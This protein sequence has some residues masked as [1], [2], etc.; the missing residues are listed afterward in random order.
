M[1]LSRRLRQKQRERKARLGRLPK[2]IHLGRGYL[3]KIEIITPTQIAEIL[4]IEEKDAVA[5]FWDDDDWVIY[6]DGSVSRKR[7]WEAYFHELIHA[8]HDTAELNRGG[9]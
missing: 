4:E 9:I 6:I 8:V 3:V 5:G 2:S 1:Q 7:Q